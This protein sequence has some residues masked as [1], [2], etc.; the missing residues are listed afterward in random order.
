MKLLLQLLTYRDLNDFYK[1][2]TKGYNFGTSVGGNTDKGKANMAPNG[3]TTIGLTHTGQEK[4][5]ITRATIGLGNITINSKPLTPT[6]LPQG[7]TVRDN[8]RHIIHFS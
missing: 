2:E 7:T 5:Q 6:P 3:S 8:F 4:E 1:E